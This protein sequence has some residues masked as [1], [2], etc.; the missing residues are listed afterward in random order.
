MSSSNDKDVESA[1]LIDSKND[2]IDS[3]PPDDKKKGG[4]GKALSSCA[5]Y[6]FCSV[7]MVLVNKS[8]ASRYAANSKIFDM[9]CSLF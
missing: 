8:L 5:L 9:S 6:G 1:A 4:S 7:S 3:S 2:A